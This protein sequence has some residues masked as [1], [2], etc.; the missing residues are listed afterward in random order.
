MHGIRELLR[1][2]PVQPFVVHDTTVATNSLLERR[3]GIA[4][5]TTGGFENVLFIGRQTW[6][7]LYR[8]GAEPREHL[9]PRSRCFGIDERTSA[10]GNVEREPSNEEVRSLI[11]KLERTKVQAVSLCLINSCAYPYS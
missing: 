1:N 4:F 6:P 8:L 11:T 2:A 9:L 10:S 3:G 7:E 5:V